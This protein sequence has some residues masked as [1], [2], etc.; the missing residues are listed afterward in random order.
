MH[1]RVVFN[2][3]KFK[4]C[5]CLIS[6]SRNYARKGRKN[7]KALKNQGFSWL[8]LFYSLFLVAGVGFW[9]FYHQRGSSPFRLNGRRAALAGSLLRLPFGVTRPAQ[10]ILN[11][12]HR[13]PP[14]PPETRL[15]RRF[16]SAPSAEG[17]NQNKKDTA[18]CPLFCVRAIKK[19]FS[20]ECLRDLNLTD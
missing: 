8:Y 4:S 1:Q 18:W 15:W 10:T 6:F 3:G 5:K 11:C 17:G 19:I 13:A 16:K 2:F 14:L 12:L 9:R 20:A 7:K